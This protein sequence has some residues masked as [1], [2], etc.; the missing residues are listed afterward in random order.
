M[1][2]VL[3]TEALGFVR[4]EFL[5]GVAVTRPG[6]FGTLGAHAHTRSLTRHVSFPRN[7]LL[8]SS[9]SESNSLLPY[10]HNSIDKLNVRRYSDLVDLFPYIA[11][12]VFICMAC[13]YILYVTYVHVFLNVN[14]HLGK[15]IVDLH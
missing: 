4:M 11:I 2:T 3:S 14:L 10:N 7:C 13:I 12:D 1:S 5:A 9:S 6:L 8:P 15:Y